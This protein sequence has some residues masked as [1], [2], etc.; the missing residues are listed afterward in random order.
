MI[1]TGILGLDDLLGGG[2][3]SGT[4]IDIFGPGGS[5]KT[6]LA[7]QISLNSLQDGTV[8]YLDATGEFSRSKRMLQLIKSKNLESSLLDD[9]IV[10]RMRNVSEQLEYVKKISELR[11]NLVV[12]DNITDLFV[13]EYDQTVNMLEKHLRF[14]EYMH[15]LSLTAINTK[16]PV[17]V[18]NMVRNMD[19]MEIESLNK[20]ISM[21]THKKIKL[22]KLE[23]DEKDEKVFKAQ[24]FPSFGKRKEILYTMTEAGLVEL[25]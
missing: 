1:S 10:A 2:I 18:T 6:Q 13:F 24:V 22:E 19:G 4:I 20:S 5:G 16:V 15:E 14:M 9:V 8:L 23:N 25:P 21:F 7:M 11:P 17:I 3:A 12:I